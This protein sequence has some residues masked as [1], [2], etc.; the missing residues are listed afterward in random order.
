MSVKLKMMVHVLCVTLCYCVTM[1]EYLRTYM[2][3]IILQA[4]YTCTYV[5]YNSCTSASDVLKKQKDSLQFS[6]KL[7]PTRA[8]PDSRK[9][10]LSPLLGRGISSGGEVNLS[11]GIELTHSAQ[12]VRTYVYLVLLYLSVYVLVI[13]C[14]CWVH[15]GY[16]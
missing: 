10:V 13:P 2:V 8:Q 4:W 11:G 1:H 5:I 6:P 3:G 9:K 14:L 7:A 12:K 16:T 15:G